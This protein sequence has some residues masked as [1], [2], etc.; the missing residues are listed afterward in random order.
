MPAELRSAVEPGL[1][2]PPLVVGAV[3]SDRDAL[4]VWIRAADR[5]RVE[6]DRAAAILGKIFLDAPHQLPPL[7]EIGLDRLRVN[8]C[9]DLG[10]AV[11]GVVALGPAEVIF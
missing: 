10:A 1:F 11:A 6:D 8:E 3:H 2:Q 9:V 7:V 4:D 5:A